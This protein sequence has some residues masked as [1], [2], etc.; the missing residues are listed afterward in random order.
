[1]MWLLRSS[2]ATNAGDLLLYP[3]I[4][5]EGRGTFTPPTDFKKDTGQSVHFAVNRLEHSSL[6][7][8]IFFRSH[9]NASRG[10]EKK[11]LG[12]RWRINYLAQSITSLKA[13]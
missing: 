2:T 1:M 11:Q 6:R 10:E 3:Y 13:Q 4:M 9:S 5:G 8:H 7:S 12:W